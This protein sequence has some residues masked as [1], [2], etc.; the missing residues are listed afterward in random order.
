M[1]DCPCATGGD[2]K[3]A[4]HCVWYA[5]P[6]YLMDSYEY[7]VGSRCRVGTLKESVM[8]YRKPTVQQ[9]FMI[10]RLWSDGSTETW[11]SCVENSWTELV[12]LPGEDAWTPLMLSETWGDQL[13]SCS[14][15]GK[16]KHGTCYGNGEFYQVVQRRLY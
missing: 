2:E 15:D 14:V 4:C 7:L 1:R 11:F 12:Y 3:R 6:F 8:P 13:V 10:V 16:I 5:L 9:L